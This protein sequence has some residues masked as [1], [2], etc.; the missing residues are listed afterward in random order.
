[1]ANK[2]RKAARRLDA[3]PMEIMLLENSNMDTDVTL[4]I[5]PAIFNR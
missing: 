1:M 3:R 4:S 5:K 2:S